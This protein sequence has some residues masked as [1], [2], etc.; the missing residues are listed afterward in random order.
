MVSLEVLLTIVNGLLSTS[1]C[2]SDTT[3]PL[4]Q[5]CGGMRGVHVQMHRSTRLHHKLRVSG[6]RKDLSYTETTRRLVRAHESHGGHTGHHG[7]VL[8]NLRRCV[9]T[10]T[11]VL[12]HH[13]V[14][15]RLQNGRSRLRGNVVEF[16]AVF[17]MNP[18]L[19]W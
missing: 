15:G 19:G 10:R 5:P 13:F 11:R 2:T 9:R 6:R 1:S 4:A 8:Q 16:V 14:G 17:D 18:H 3:P 12:D 7:R